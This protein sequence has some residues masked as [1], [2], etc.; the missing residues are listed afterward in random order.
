[1]DENNIIDIAKVSKIN[2]ITIPKSVRKILNLIIHDRVIFI[3]E[4]DVV[5]I[6]KL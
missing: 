5:I 6:K 2:Q 4:K 1:M 3:K